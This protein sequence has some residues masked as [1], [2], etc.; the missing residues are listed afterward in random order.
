[1]SEY[2]ENSEAKAVADIV[3][4]H[5][6]SDLL[7]VTGGSNLVPVEVLIL[8]NGDGLEVHSVKKYVDEYRTAPEFRK[9]TA[10]LLDQDSF[11]AHANRFKDDDS[12]IFADNDRETPSLKS[13]LNYH[14]QKHDGAPRF[15]DHKGVYNFPMSDE[16]K[17]WAEFDGE[18]RSQIEFAEF[19]EDRITDVE[20]PPDLSKIKKD[21]EPG[22]RLKKMLDILGGKMA[23]PGT[24]MDLSRGMKV[25]AEEKVH[26]SQNLST[27]EG[28]IQYRQEHRD[29]QGAPLKVPNMFLIGIPV[30]KNGDVF[31]IAVRLR[32]RVRAGQ[33]SWSYMLYRTDQVFDAAFNDV[34]NKV[35][36]DTDLPVFFGRPE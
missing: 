23:G 4:R 24:L 9:G 29:E 14:R 12:V 10:S 11:V 33:I 1:M 22:Q 7:K 6:K 36:A 13:V 5:I 16:W 21:D 26:Q 32:Y 25:T 2:N 28:Q 27:G 34:V 17:A 15:G 8:P 35:K 19:L 20:T 18:V 30:F 31:R 3:R